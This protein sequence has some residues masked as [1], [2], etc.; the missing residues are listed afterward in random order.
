MASGPVQER[1]PRPRR[2][3]RC[4][5]ALAAAF[6][7]TSCYVTEQGSR[8]LTLIS[9]AVPVA[10]ALDDPK[11]DAALRDLIERAQAAARF[12][13]DEL[14]MKRTRNF[15][16]IVELEGDRLATVV[17]ACA[18]LSFDRWLWSYPVVGKLPYRGYFDPEEARAE[19]ARLKSLGKDVIVRPVDAFSSLGWLPDPLF[20]PMAAYDEA[21]VAELV[22]H[23][24]MHATVFLKGNGAGVE[25][26]NEELATFVGREGAMLALASIHGPDSA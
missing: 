11:T 6:L 7:S 24:M 23:E 14:G 26:F 20:S 16:S 12:A 15:S 13:V 8:Y 1:D 19:A 5:T 4:A 18:E 17:Q 10:R 2:F 22:I 3:A 25:Q 21:E 9:R